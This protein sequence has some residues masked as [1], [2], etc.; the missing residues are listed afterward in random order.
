[1]WPKKEFNFYKK[2]FFLNRT[3]AKKFIFSLELRLS[4]LNR[5]GNISDELDLRTII[6]SLLYLCTFISIYLVLYKKIDTSSK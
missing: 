6:L 4:P 5:M 2:N 3:M 1:M